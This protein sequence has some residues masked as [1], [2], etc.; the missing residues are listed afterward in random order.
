MR[1]GYGRAHGHPRANWVAFRT[2]RQRPAAVG[3]TEHGDPV[4]E[5]RSVRL[6]LR[7]GASHFNRLVAC[8]KCRREIVGTALLA[9]ADLERTPS[10]VICEK[11]VKSSRTGAS[12][13]PAETPKAGTTPAE[14]PEAETLAAETPEVEIPVVATDRVRPIRPEM[15]KALEIQRQELAALTDAVSRLQLEIVDLEQRFLTALDQLHAR[16][17]RPPAG[18]PGPASAMSVGDS[19]EAQLQAAERRLAAR[20]DAPPIDV[21]IEPGEGE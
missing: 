8:S 21:L 3:T 17:D 1:D 20:T 5:V 14:A 6:V 18:P 7:D 16:L 4:F 10:P 15:A 13:P 12:W 2:L 19:L 9:P 11:C